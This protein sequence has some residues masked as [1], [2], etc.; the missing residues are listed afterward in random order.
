M[1]RI[2]IVLLSCFLFSC[3]GKKDK[4]VKNEEEIGGFQYE[5]F[6]KEFRKGELPYVLSDT[7]LVKINGITS[8]DGA[9]I[10]PFIPDSIKV[11]F[12]KGSKLK[13]VPILNFYNGNSEQYFLVKTS[14]ASKSGALLLIFDKEQ[15]FATALPFLLPD[16][17][18][19]TSQNTV[20]DKSFTI[21]K[22][23][24]QKNKGETVGEGKDV[25]AY[26]KAEKKFTIIM[27]DVL[28]ENTAVFINPIDTFPAT[29]QLAGDYFLNKKNLVSI[30]DGRHLNQLLIYIH[31]QNEDGD[32]SGELKGEAL[33]TSTTAATYRLGGDP[34]VLNL[35]FG[36]NSIT[37]KEESGCGNH[38]GLN[39][40]LTGTF[41]RKKELKPKQSGKKKTGK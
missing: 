38:R 36:G 1:Y 41:T 23:V 34:C 3:K 22:N 25:L 26:D 7:A 9:L 27:T 4:E 40:P 17:D 21:F 6:A 35:S 18:P 13:F 20:I 39:C 28:S 30:R 31:T 16:N 15:A 5:A 14:S 24:V 37:L 33:I 8:L 32:C 11:L 10:S 12:G 19:S 2:G 29:H